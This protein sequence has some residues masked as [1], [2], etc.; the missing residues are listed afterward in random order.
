MKKELKLAFCLFKYFP[1]G[2]LQKNFINI[3]KESSLRGYKTDVYAIFWEGEKPEGVNINILPVKGFTN[4]KRYKSFAEKINKIKKKKNYDAVIGFN[5]MPG[6][7]LYYTADVSYAAKMHNRNVLQKMTGRYRTLMWLENEV[8]KKDSKTKILLLTTKEKEFYKAYYK[9]S[10]DRFFVMPPGISKKCIPPSN[11]DEVRNIKRKELNIEENTIVLLMIC[12]NFKIKGVARA[13]KALSSLGPDTLDKTVLV[14]AGQDNPA[15][16]MGL[17][18]RLKVS[19]KVKFIG[20]RKDVPDLLMASDVLLHP[21]LIENTGTV[22]VEA[23][24]ANLP[25]ITT[26]VCGYSFHVALADAGKVIESPFKQ[27]DLDKDLEFMLKMSDYSQFKSNAKIY[28][29]KTDVFSRA[30]KAVDVIEK[31]CA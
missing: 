7:D 8:F 28:I 29:E 18:K 19:E 5:K 24:A 27:D 9:T 31:V 10:P 30:K 13:I 6:L 20:V 15:S 23:L 12:T 26:D 16:Y 17:A 11:S 21:A 22:I 14:V 4:H 3:L 1:F 25:V 2:G